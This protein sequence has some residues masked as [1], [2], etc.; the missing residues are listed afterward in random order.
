VIPWAQADLTTPFSADDA[1]VALQNHVLNLRRLF[2]DRAVGT[3]DCCALDRLSGDF[4][5]GDILP[6][7]DH[8]LP[9]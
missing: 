3:D 1:V 2:S 4:L 9:E 5:R 8:D 6:I 7:F